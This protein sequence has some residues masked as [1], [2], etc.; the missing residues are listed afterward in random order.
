MYRIDIEE[1]IDRVYIRDFAGI[2]KF[3]LKVMISEED[4]GGK[5]YSRHFYFYKKVR[6]DVELYISKE[7]VE[8]EQIDIQ[9]FE[10]KFIR[11]L[12]GPAKR[13]KVLDLLLNINRDLC[14]SKNKEDDSVLAFFNKQ[15]DNYVF[16][17]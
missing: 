6:K 5:I 12:Y 10:L 2:N 17:I 11:R 1:E 8:I 15:I 16:E 7:I 4:G 3:K 13:D 14:L 9:G